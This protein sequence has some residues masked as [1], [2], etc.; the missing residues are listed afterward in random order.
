MNA[1]FFG[2]NT[3]LELV[4]FR[5]DQ[6]K[7]LRQVELDVNSEEPHYFELEHVNGNIYFLIECTMVR[8]V[9]EQ[10]LDVY[11]RVE[12]ALKASRIGDETPDSP[13]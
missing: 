6:V 12:Q 11:D 7:D 5:G 2:V 9:V 13:R 4:W 1:V 8:G 10:V 3:G